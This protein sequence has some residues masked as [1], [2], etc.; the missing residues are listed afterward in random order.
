MGSK[1]ELILIDTNI[2]V[3][4]LRYRGDVNYKTNQ[5]FLASI[6]QNGSGFTTLVNLLELCGILSFNLNQDQ[7]ID[8]FTYFQDRYKVAV[9][10]EPDLKMNFPNIKIKRLFEILGEKAALGDALMISVAEN[11]L[12]FVSTLVTWD[13]AHF[14]DKFTGN[15][16]T[17][18]E[19]LSGLD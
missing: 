19:F 3:I 16:L 17:P 9:L 14:K 18:V 10:P 11:Y 5:A 8:L 6:A 2:F 4:D 13:N 15:V 7:L 12:P 1:Q